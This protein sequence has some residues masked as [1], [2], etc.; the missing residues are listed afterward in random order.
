LK[1]TAPSPKGPP[2]VNFILTPLSAGD[3][4]PVLTPSPGAKTVGG[5]PESTIGITTLSRIR[6]NHSKP[7]LSARYLRILKYERVLRR[8]KKKEYRRLKKYDCE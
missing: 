5:G 6:I 2:V 4:L 1:L 8:L 3:R 7:E